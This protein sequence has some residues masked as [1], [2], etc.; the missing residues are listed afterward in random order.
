VTTPASAQPSVPNYAIKNAETVAA[1]TG[2]R[3]R[4]FTLAPSE[5]I[6]WHFHSA[7][8]DEFFLLVGELTVETRK[9]DDCRVLGVGERYRVNGGHAHQTSNRRAHDCRFLIVQGIGKYDFKV[10][11]GGAKCGSQ[12]RCGHI[13]TR[14]KSRGHCFKCES[15]PGKRCFP[16]QP[17]LATSLVEAGT[18][19][20]YEF[21]AR[22]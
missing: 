14:S 21:H 1:G 6:P 2:V 10:L 15:R 16:T 22:L 3:V 5:V 18:D 17:N 11:V 13:N 7:I 9:P 19:A 8:A 12:R 20:I 4:L